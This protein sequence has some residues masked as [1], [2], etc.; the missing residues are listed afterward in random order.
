MDCYLVDF[1]ASLDLS[2]QMYTTPVSCNNLTDDSLFVCYKLQFDLTNA[3]AVAG[4]LITIAKL[5][6][7]ITLSAL[8]WLMNRQTGKL[9]ILIMFNIV[10]SLVTFDCI[11][12][13]ALL[14]LQI[15]AQEV[16]T[17]FVTDGFTPIYS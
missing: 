16:T 9:K 15:F 1:P 17:I 13:I 2:K 11:F 4:G 6:I 10:F 5:T 14:L 12:T 3:L 8:S 7:N